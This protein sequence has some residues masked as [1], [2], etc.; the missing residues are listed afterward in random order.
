MLHES[1][2]ARED[3]KDR[4]NYWLN[5]P[6][7][8]D[9]LPSGLPAAAEDTLGWLNPVGGNSSEINELEPFNPAVVGFDLLPGN[10]YEDEF[11]HHVEEEF[12]ASF[13]SLGPADDDPLGSW[14]GVPADEDE[15]P[16]QD[17]D[18]L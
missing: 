10:E 9:M 8:A 16:T 3:A 13:D 11:E 7:G 15:I 2:D 1:Y 14:T 12:D 4:D 5:I 18:D 6:E 17:A